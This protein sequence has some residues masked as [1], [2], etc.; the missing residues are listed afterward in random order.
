MRH[1]KGVDYRADEVVGGDIVRARHGKVVL[2]ELADNQ[3]TTR[4]VGKIAE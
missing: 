2:V 4:L 3:S 1:V